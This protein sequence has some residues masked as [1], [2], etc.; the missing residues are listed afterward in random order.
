MVNSIQSTISWAQSFGVG[1]AFFILTLAA[2]GV[3]GLALWVVSIALK[4]G[5]H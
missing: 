2:L 5:R 4:K 1:G 3:C